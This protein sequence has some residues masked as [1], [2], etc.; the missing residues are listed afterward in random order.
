M[1]EEIVNVINFEIRREGGAVMA[2]KTE[3]SCFVEI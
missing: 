3:T 1:A 2:K